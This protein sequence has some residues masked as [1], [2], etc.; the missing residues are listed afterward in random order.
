MGILM[1]TSKGHMMFEKY[2]HGFR[3]QHLSDTHGSHQVFGVI[4]WNALTVHLIQAD[5]ILFILSGVFL[6]LNK[7]SSAALMLIVALAFV[8]ATK[9]NPV[10]QSNLKSIANE[11]AQRL[12]DFCKHASLIGAAVFIYAC[13]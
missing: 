5:G 4:S 1:L 13:Q 7:R 3:K 2:V 9:D 11:Q 6:L 10:M 8:L 12:K